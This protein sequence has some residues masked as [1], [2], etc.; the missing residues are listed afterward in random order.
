VLQVV[1]RRADVTLDEEWGDQ[2]PRT[3]IVAIAAVESIDAENLMEYFNA[4]VH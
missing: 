4:C 2:S 3:Q 1:G